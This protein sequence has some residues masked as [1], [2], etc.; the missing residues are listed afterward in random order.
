[1]RHELVRLCMCAC[2][3]PI[4]YLEARHSLDNYQT[5]GTVKRPGCAYVKDFVQIKRV[6]AALLSRNA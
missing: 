3:N 2:D 4:V 5:Y 1:M 6:C